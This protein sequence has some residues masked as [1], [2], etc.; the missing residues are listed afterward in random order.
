MIDLSRRQLL[1]GAAAETT[2]RLK[3]G[4]PFLQTQRFQNWTF[5]HLHL[6]NRS[7]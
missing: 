5:M 1:A 6:S 4:R 2:G 7:G 3:K